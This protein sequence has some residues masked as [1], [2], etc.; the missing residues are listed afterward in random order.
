MRKA[1]SKGTLLEINDEFPL[2]NVVMNSLKQEDRGKLKLLLRMINT[3]MNKIRHVHEDQDLENVESSI[4]SE[5]DILHNTIINLIS[6]GIS[7][8]IIKNS[9]IPNMGIKISSLPSS[10]LNLIH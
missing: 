7:K 8:E 5:A 2:I 4:S 6:A 3:Q 9:I 1:T 10:I